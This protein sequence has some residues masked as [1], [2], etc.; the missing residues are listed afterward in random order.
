MTNQAQTQ[1]RGENKMNTL[2]K[3]TML[4]SMVFL[5]CAVPAMAQIDNRVTFEAPFAFYAGNA[6]MPAGSYT[7]TQPDLNA[8]LLL[9][10]S[11]DGSHSVFVEYMTD[12]SNTPASKTE[13]TFNKYA[14][15]E[16]LGRISVQGQ[17][18]ME[19]LTSKAEQ[20]A[21]TVAAAEKHTLS[22]KNGR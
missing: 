4:M 9:L 11:A 19:I 5:F 22:A 6:K 13:I 3:L 18:S 16:F 7:V 20:N 14:N 2:N 12:E 10:E 17:N 21:A 8:E 15:T 1:K